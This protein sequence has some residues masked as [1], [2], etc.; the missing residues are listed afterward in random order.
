M[1]IKLKNTHNRSVLSEGRSNNMGFAFC[2]NTNGDEYETIQP[3][4]PCKDYLNDVIFAE[5]TN[6]SITAYGL[7]LKGSQGLFKGKQAYIAIAMCPY[8]YKNPYNDKG[9]LEDKARLAKYHKHLESF[10][11]YFEELLGI[12]AETNTIITEV[13]DN[14]YVIELPLLWTES[15]YMI[16]LYSLLLRAGQT[17]DDISVDPMKFLEDNK[18]YQEDISLVKSAL[19]KLNDIIKYGPLKQDFSILQG[20][21]STHNLGIVAYKLDYSSFKVEKATKV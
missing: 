2:K 9:F 4:S 15:T 10:I 3:I 16:S 7:S 18:G 13:E 17:Y 8:K 1:G 14:L 6:K 11:N 5:V 21:T 20:N 19:P 12:D